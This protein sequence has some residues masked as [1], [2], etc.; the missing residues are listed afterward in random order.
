M[1]PFYGRAPCQS[2]M[3]C[4]QGIPGALHTPP[5]QTRH[6]AARMALLL[7][8]HHEESMAWHRRLRWVLAPR[9]S[10]A[11][12]TAG[13]RCTTLRKQ[14][15]MGLATRVLGLTQ[16]WRLLRW[17]FGRW[18]VWVWV[19]VVVAD[20][21]FRNRVGIRPTTSSPSCRHAFGWS[22]LVMSRDVAPL[23]A[24]NGVCHECASLCSVRLAC[25]WVTCTP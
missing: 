13:V 11:V 19:W 25:W 17:V 21:W 16:L 3:G 20:R 23:W 1:A 22:W 12:S 8:R 6:Q 9:C 5:D 15:T 7:R 10:T 2:D 18:W 14:L 4:A 24:L